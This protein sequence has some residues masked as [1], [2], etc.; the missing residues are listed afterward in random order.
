MRARYT[1]YVKSKVAF[2]LESSHPNLRKTLDEKAT[3]TWAKGS[4]WH[5]LQI[6]STEKGTSQ[7][8]DGVVEFVC[9]YSDKEQ[10][11][12]LHE[13]AKFVKENDQWYYLDGEIVP[14]KPYVREQPKVGRNDPCP[15]G[16]GKKYKKCHGLI[17]S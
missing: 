3:E 10:M 11:R 14:P 1:S 13:R 5:G 8:T 15:C 16:S 6:V 4:M 2:I 7:D 9:E 17:D 12:T